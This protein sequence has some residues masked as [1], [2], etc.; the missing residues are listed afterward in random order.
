MQIKNAEITNTFLGYQ[1]GILTYMIY[2]SFVGG[3]Q[4]FGGRELGGKYTT[5]CINGIL[6]AVGVE[7]WE[8]L[9]G[10][11]IRIKSDFEP[12][13]EIKAIGHII[14]DIWFEE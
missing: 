10:K 2:V 5:H 12:G 4:G 7:N 6:H 13:S 1:H 8:G 14:N 11:F 9:I 3:D